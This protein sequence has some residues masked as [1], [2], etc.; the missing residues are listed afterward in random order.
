LAKEAGCQDPPAVI[1]PAAR[2]IIREKSGL[3][4][5]ALN[6]H[7]RCIGYS[8]PRVTDEVRE[9]IRTFFTRAQALDS[10][11]ETDLLKTKLREQVAIARKKIGQP[12]MSWVA[13]ITN[14][15]RQ[16]PKVPGWPR[17]PLSALVLRQQEQLIKKENPHWEP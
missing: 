15:Q 6:N 2:L 9:L 16:E 17:R 13:I 7:L 3:N 12:P 10:K 14:A 11:E 1:S 5:P 8:A 4:T